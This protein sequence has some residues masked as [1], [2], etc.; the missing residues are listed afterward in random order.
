MFAININVKCKFDSQFIPDYNDLNSQASQILIS[1]YTNFV[2][3]F[4]FLLIIMQNF[5]FE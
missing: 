5:K 2:N 4:T 1:S 3:Y